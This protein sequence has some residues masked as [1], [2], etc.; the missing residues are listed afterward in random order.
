MVGRLGSRPQDLTA[1]LFGGANVLPFSPARDTVGQQNVQ[2]AVERL[3]AL[4]ITVV[5]RRTGGEAG[6]LVRFHT[7]SGLALVRTLTS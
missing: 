1:K 4:G 7:D 2:L 3:R 6:L 5:A